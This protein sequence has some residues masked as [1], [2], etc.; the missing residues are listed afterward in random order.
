MRAAVALWLLVAGGVACRR[1]P[2]PEPA[3]QAAATPAVQGPYVWHLP[4]GVPQPVVPADNPMSEAKVQLGRRLFYDTRLSGNQTYACATC[5]EQRRA[6]TD[7]RARAIGSTEG[8][9]PRSTMTLTNAAFN[10]SY[11]WADPSLRTLEAQMRVPL[12]N[13]HPV[14][15]GMAGNEEKILGRFQ[16]ADDRARF[17]AA[18]PAE[19]SPT[20]TSIIKAIASFERTIVSGSSPLDRYLYLDDRAALSPAA[21]NGMKLFFSSRL[22]CSGCH[23]GFNLSGPAD[24]LVAKVHPKPAFHNTGLYDVD[25]KGSYP[26]ADQG[27]KDVTGAAGDM[28]QFRAPTLRNIAVTAP[29]MHDG[30]IATLD[31]V[32][33]H[34]AS[35]GRRSRFRSRAVRGFTLSRS[36]R[37]DLLAFLASLTDR[38]FLTSPAL[39]RPH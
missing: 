15:M 28:G 19:A 5:H 32:L 14:E 17:A 12:L 39:A 4:A 30:S 26:D 1:T 21:A 6:F 34:Y 9:H 10:A 3:P 8:V 29:Y 25:G 24:F 11:G 18:F 22:R 38:A 20:L 36:E 27:L 16:T 23:G 2:P 37:D 7:G 33:A 35:G 31:G 13:Q